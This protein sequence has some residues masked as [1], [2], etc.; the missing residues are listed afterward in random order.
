LLARLLLGGSAW[1]G[2]PKIILA[3]FSLVHLFIGH[4]IT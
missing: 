1:L 3:L 4:S 2:S